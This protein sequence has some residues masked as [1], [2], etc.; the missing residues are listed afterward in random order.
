MVKFGTNQGRNNTVDLEPLYAIC[1]EDETGKTRLLVF[2]YEFA[3]TKIL[4][5]ELTSP[6]LELPAL[7]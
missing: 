4:V 6:P 3:S 7:L 5:I 2:N 1:G